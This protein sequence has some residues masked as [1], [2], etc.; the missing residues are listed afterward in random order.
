MREGTNPD[1]KNIRGVTPLWIAAAYEHE[2]VVKVLAHRTDVNV[3]SVS[4]SGRPPLF[5]PSSKGNERVVAVL[6]EAGADPD[7]VDENGATPVNVARKNGHGRVVKIL[8]Q[9]REN[10]L[11]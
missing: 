2:A 3:N 6:I 11:A 10:R 9:S 1:T 5:W 4:V 7:L 8:E